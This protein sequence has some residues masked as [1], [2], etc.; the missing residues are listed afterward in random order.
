MPPT[1]ILEDPL[2]TDAEL[3]SHPAVAYPGD[4]RCA[5]GGTVAAC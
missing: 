4:G 3:A 5:S 2:S 1:P